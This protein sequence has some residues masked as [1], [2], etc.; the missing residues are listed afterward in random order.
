[1]RFPDRS[2]AIAV[3][4]GA[5]VLLAILS[6]PL[7]T[8]RVYSQH[9]LGWQYL[10]IHIFYADCLVRGEPFDWMPQL[11]GGHFLTGEGELG[12]YHP[13][14][15]LMY[16]WL[17]VTVAFQL[18]V[19]LPVLIMLAG[20]TWFLRRFIGLGGALAGALFFSFSVKFIWHLDIPTYGL[21]MA[22][23]PWLL[24]AVDVAMTT[25]NSRHRNW[26]GAA[27]AFL[28]GS[29][30]ACGFP[31]TL[32]FLVLTE[33]AFCL[34]LLLC[35]AKSWKGWATI[36]GGN[37]LGIGIG[38]VQLLT[39]AAYTAV[40]TRAVVAPDFPDVGAL[41][42]RCIVG[43]VAPYLLYD[44]VPGW[45]GIYFGAVPLVLTVWWLGCAMWAAPHPATPRL[46][47]R[48]KDVRRFSLFLL[49]YGL[50]A[51]WLALGYYGKLY[52][53]QTYL[54]LVGKLRGPERF[55]GLTT[56]A[57]AVLGGIAVARL[58]AVVRDGEK[59]PW[60]SLLLP[61]LL[62]PVSFLVAAWY[63]QSGLT[64]HTGPLQSKLYS[65]PLIFTAVAAALTFAARGHNCGVVLLV[66]L[67]TVD[68][69]LYGMGNPH[70]RFY[71]APSQT[72]TWD[73]YVVSP[74]KPPS[75]DE[76]RIADTA[77]DR[78][79]L[80]MNG[81][82]LINGYIGGSEPNRQLDYTHVNSLRVAEVA[83]F[84]DVWNPKLETPGLS[85]TSGRAWRRV[86]HPLPRARLVSKVLSSNAPGDDLKRID[87]DQVAL[88]SRPLELPA[89]RPGLTAI[90]QE[91][92]GRIALHVSSPQR[93]LL[94]F[95]ES[96]D[97]GWQV[98]VD[99]NLGLLEKVNGDFMGCVVEGGDHQ[100][101]FAFRPSVLWW[102]KTLSLIG[103]AL[104][105][106]WVAIAWLTPAG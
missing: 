95:A 75:R 13:L 36:I 51:L 42:P 40:S 105:L 34:Y 73:Q 1:M 56:L 83:W 85:P 24:G 11:F 52:Y 7:V 74:S 94:V 77:M 98:R 19:L 3:V 31:Q 88:V 69:G 32:W 10:P 67:A 64:V 58:C 53:L 79:L 91:R 90:V 70:L 63:F 45:G 15:L 6:Q 44:K 96:Y 59:L 23:I 37:L 18:E 99:G 20:M 43:I 102:G 9:D 35:G 21:I 71:W 22:H 47:D 61:W 76:G 97:K 81:Y 57:T 103:A 100:V 86:P 48:W 33:A 82:R 46:A 14:H 84:R 5:L 65:A 89:S 92:P 4:V 49:V 55:H 87:V 26:A 16:R 8:N 28:F 78:N 54:P 38:A 62:V 2:V 68:L 17:P 60:K 101:E 41:W 106:C 12:P 72:I 27:I 50:V 39:T 25:S 80:W 93:Q 29:A 66:V 104:G 30:I